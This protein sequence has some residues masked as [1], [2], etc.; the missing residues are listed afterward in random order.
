[1]RKVVIHQPNFLPYLGFFEQ[2]SKA[3]VYI[4]YDNVQ[5]TENEFQNRNFVKSQNGKDNLT[6]SVKKKGRFGQL[7]NQVEI[8]SPES[9]RNTYNKLEACYRKAPYWDEV[10]VPIRQILFNDI[11]LMVDINIPL[12]KMICINI[13]LDLEHRVSSEFDIVYTDRLDRIFKLMDAVGAKTLVAGDGAATYMNPMDFKN[14]GLNLV[15]H[16]FEPKVY[17]QSHGEFLPYLSV[18]DYLMNVGWKYWR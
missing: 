12:I 10:C 1:M 11:D 6:L 3:D 7:I 2:I 8:S 9:R 14:R 15:I 4:A 5:F 13:G 18:V 16:S 17:P